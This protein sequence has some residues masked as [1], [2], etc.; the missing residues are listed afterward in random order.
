MK[1]IFGVAIVVLIL[2]GLYRYQSENYPD[3]ASLHSKGNK[4]YNPHEN[5]LLNGNVYQAGT[6]VSGPG[7]YLL[8]CTA[9]N[10]NRGD[11]GYVTWEQ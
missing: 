7:G 8:T 11:D 2:C 5:C 3:S 6:R 1:Y 4:Q 9:T 10:R